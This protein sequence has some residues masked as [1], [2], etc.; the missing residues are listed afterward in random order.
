MQIRNLIKRPLIIITLALLA[1]PILIYLEYCTRSN[2]IAKISSLSVGY[3][4]NEHFDFPEIL[5]S[6]IDRLLVCGSIDNQEPHY[7]SIT[8]HDIS[9]RKYYGKNDSNNPFPSGSFCSEI[10]L[11]Y[12]LASGDYKLII[13]NKHSRVGELIFQVK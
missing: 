7:L 4:K 9:E 13:I 1:L 8:L 12:P 2:E 3:I 11:R 5:P 10:V 6:G